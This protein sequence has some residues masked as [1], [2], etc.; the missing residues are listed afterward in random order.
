[1]QTE[2]PMDQVRP[3]GKHVLVK[4]CP[5]AEMHGGFVVPD[6]YRDRNKLKGDLFEGIVI[7]F[8][9]RTQA[10]RHSGFYMPGDK[11]YFWNL[12]DWKDK[13]VVLKDSTSGDEYLLV[14]ESDI[15]AFE[16]AEVPNV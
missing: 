16:P 7:A 3:A 1:M 5:V 15:S 9:D 6:E 12:W 10:A 13:R 4:R 8:G 11:V 14:D 2:I